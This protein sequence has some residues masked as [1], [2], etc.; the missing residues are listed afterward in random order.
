MRQRAGLERKP[1][2]VIK[3]TPT[4]QPPYAAHREV[5]QQLSQWTQDLRKK[6][7]EERDDAKN[8]RRTFEPAGVRLPSAIVDRPNPEQF[9][10]VVLRQRGRGAERRSVAFDCRSEMDHRLFNSS[11][12]CGQIAVTRTG[13]LD[14]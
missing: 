3:E 11:I 8:K 2:K 4:A 10:R 9:E 1:L 12:R 14:F 5:T 13:S 7:S 6:I